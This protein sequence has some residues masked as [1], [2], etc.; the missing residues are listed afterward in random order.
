MSSICRSQECIAATRWGDAEQGQ[1]AVGE[2]LC[3]FLQ[4]RCKLLTCSVGAAG[5]APSELLNRSH[6]SQTHK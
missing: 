4:P 6:S 1:H 3:L 2:F 5:V